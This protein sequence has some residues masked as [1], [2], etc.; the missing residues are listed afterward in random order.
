MTNSTAGRQGTATDAERLN[1]PQSSGVQFRRDEAER[2]LDAVFGSTEG[3]AHLAS[4]HRR[5]L[6]IVPGNAGG[7]I[8]AGV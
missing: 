5:T 3:E 4:I 1:A 7:V 8:V 2:Y 6:A